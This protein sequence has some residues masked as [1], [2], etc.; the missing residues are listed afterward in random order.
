MDSPVA[1][2][3]MKKCRG[4]DVVVRRPKGEAVFTIVSVTYRKTQAE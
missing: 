3:L 4:D 2:A 1:R